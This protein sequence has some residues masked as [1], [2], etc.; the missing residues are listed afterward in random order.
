[1]SVT[2]KEVY[3]V[4]DELIYNAFKIHLIE[5]FT[6]EEKIYKARPNVYLLERFKIP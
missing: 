1:M 5:P 4:V 6:K 2:Y 3:E